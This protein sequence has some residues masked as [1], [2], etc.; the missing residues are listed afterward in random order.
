[1][2]FSGYRGIWHKEKPGNCANSPGQSQT[3]NHYAQEGFDYD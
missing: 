3:L 2:D 1:M